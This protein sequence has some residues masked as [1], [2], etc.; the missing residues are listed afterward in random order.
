LLRR[1]YLADC[2]RNTAAKLD[3]FIDDKSR[4]EGV[5]VSELHLLVADEIL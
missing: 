3:L 1:E 5:R 2:I 4:E